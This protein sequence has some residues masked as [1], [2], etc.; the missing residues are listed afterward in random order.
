LEKA[1]EKELRSLLATEMLSVLFSQEFAF[2]KSHKHGSVWLFP[3]FLPNPITSAILRLNAFD[4]TKSVYFEIT[5]RTRTVLLI[6]S[7]K[8]IH[9]NHLPC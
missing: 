6:S 2:P 3:S 9:Q 1:D 4:K 7:F 5:G 8:P